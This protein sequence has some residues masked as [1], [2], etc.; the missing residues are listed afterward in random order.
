M[1]P[2]SSPHGDRRGVNCGLSTNRSLGPARGWRPSTAIK[3]H[4]QYMFKSRRKKS[5]KHSRTFPG[6]KN[7]AHV[8]F[9]CQVG[10]MES[11]RHKVGLP[12][13]DS[14]QDDPMPNMLAL[15]SPL[16]QLSGSDSRSGT[17]TERCGQEAGVVPRSKIRDPF[18]CPDPDIR[19]QHAGLI[20]STSVSASNNGLWSA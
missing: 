13:K 3:I 4:R 6:G 16:R 2:Q 8:L 18:D 11:R 5:D 14:D 9:S 1:V 10:R 7:A 17:G 12:R 20:D 15:I 19:W